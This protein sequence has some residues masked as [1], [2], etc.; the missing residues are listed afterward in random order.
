MLNPTKRAALLLGL[1]A[2]TVVAAQPRDLNQS[3]SAVCE[4]LGVP[5]AAVAFVRDGEITAVGVAGVR[6]LGEKQPVQRGDLLMIGSCGKALTK[7]LIGRLVDRGLLQLDAT[8][9][10]LLPDVPMRDEYKTVKLADLMAHRGG[11]PPYTEIGP[12]MTPQL[13]NQTGTPTEQRAAFIKHLLNESPVAKP[14]TRFVYSNAGFALLGHIAE[15][16]SRKPYEDTLREFVFEPLGMKSSF[17]DMPNSEPGRA[18]L[19]GHL[20][21]GNAYEPMRKGW[22]PPATM[23]PAG[24]MSLSI[25]DFARFAAALA[26]CQAGKPNDFLKPT[27]AE[28]LREGQPGGEGAAFYGGDGFYT[29]AVALWPSK[30]VAIVVGTNAGENDQA[31]DEI[32]KMARET[33]APDLA[34]GAAGGAASA[35]SNRPRYGFK[36]RTEGSESGDTMTIESVESGLPADRAGLKT[37]DRVVAINGDA[38]DKLTPEKRAEALRQPELKFTV[39]RDGKRIDIAMKRGD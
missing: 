10:E 23:A 17:V 19:V 34:S 21:A 27:T 14:G 8:L 26:A 39:E 2:T 24:M 15:R 6:Q 7:L 38:I 37:G 16:A 28:L 29:A 5:G 33:C 11:I 20:R 13:F 1:A 25:D 30:G 31:C 36:I 4:K 12:K 18:G 9:A 22:K 3:L 35:D 32:I